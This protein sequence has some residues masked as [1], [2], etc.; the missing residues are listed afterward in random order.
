[1]RLKPIQ[2]DFS[3]GQISPLMYGR[4]DSKGYTAGL[5][6]CTNMTVD[7]R[8]PCMRRAGFS[9]FSRINYVVT[10]H[11][12][13]GAPV[14]DYTQPVNNAVIHTFRVSTKNSRAIVITEGTMFVVAQGAS[15][16]GDSQLTNPGFVGG[17]SGWTVD[18]GHNNASVTFAD[19]R[20]YFNTPDAQAARYAQISQTFTPDDVNGDYAFRLDG[21]FNGNG[22]TSG[23]SVKIGTA[24]DLDDIVAEQVL[25][26]G[27]RL[28]T[29]QFTLTGQTSV[30]I[31]VRAYGEDG[32]YCDS[33]NL[34]SDVSASSDFQ[35]FAVPWLE[36]ELQ[37]IHSVMDFTGKKMYFTH[38][39]HPPQTLRLNPANGVWFHEE[40]SFTD[41]PV[42]WSA[43]G[44]PTS[45]PNY[46]ATVTMF[47]GRS[48]WGGTPNEPT[49]FWASASGAYEVFTGI[50]TNT[51]PSAPMQFKLA[52]NGRIKW[53]GGIKNL[54]IGT[55]FGE[56]IVT[57]QEG[58]IIPADISVEQQ[59][60][61]GSNSVQ[62]TKLGNEM[63]FVSPDHRRIRSL[64]YQWIEDGFLSRDLSYISDNITRG[65]VITCT[66]IQNP[67]TNLWFTTK[68]G[69]LLG[70]SYH[71]DDSEMPIYGWHRHETNG[72]FTDTTDIHVD[73]VLELW[74]TTLRSVEGKNEIHIERIKY[75]DREYLDGYIRQEQSTARTTV[76]GLDHLEGYEV[77]PV[78]DGAVEPVKTVVGGEIATENAGQVIEVG[79]NYT[80]IMATLPQITATQTGSN[81]ADMKRFA[82]IFLRI[83]N[84]AKPIINGVRPATRFPQ[85]PMDV[86]QDDISEDVQVADT[87]YDR[88]GVITVEQDLPLPLWINMIH[89]WMA[90][91][92]Y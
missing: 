4:Y 76:I 19:D 48:W 63:L 40:T 88:N 64:R 79:L 89:G 57:S 51:D 70:C 28:Y 55:D 61:H 13:Q 50:V 17:G 53:M 90:S 35:A 22:L 9:H 74:A 73:G 5:L 91:N 92:S 80:S 30:T 41:P 78:V 42:E 39:N 56:Y 31:T 26:S 7:A 1:M 14:P 8:G 54:V 59:S 15:Q 32:S 12:V 58:V 33:V 60:S 52:E 20:A 81:A 37:E 82:K 27:S 67:D 46:P 21:L 77:Q 29:G 34:Y 87:G 43:T 38:Q 25:N 23:V 44:S 36:D 2:S 16:E 84:S 6:E 62:G 68:S 85:T 86:R 45:G 83:F 66:V 11:D 69:E 10:N 3:A 65:E 72:Y 75:D 47:Q 49:S 18:T 71:R 24:V